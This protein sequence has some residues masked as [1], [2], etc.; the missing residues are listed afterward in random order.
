MSRQ[1][2]V[3][4]FTTTA[5]G[6]VPAPLTAT[7]TFL[8]DDGTWAAVPG[9]TS[10]LTTKGDIFG[11]STVN[12]RI[13]V[14]ADGTVLTADSTQALGVKWSAS[15]GSGTVT[16]VALLDGSST[17]IYTITGSPVTTAG[18]LT[19]TFKTQTANTV[20]AGPTSGGAAQPTF[21]TLVA[22]DGVVGIGGNV[23][24]LTQA[25]GA[26]QNYTVPTGANWLQVICVAGGGGGGSGGIQAPTIASTGGGGGGGGGISS[27]VFRAQDL[28]PTVTVTFSNAA[29]GGNGGASLAASGAGN[30]GVAGS[31]V[32]F[33]NHIIAYGGANGTGA[34][35]GA[36][37]LGMMASGTAGG[38]GGSGAGAGVSGT[39][40]SGGTL[41]ATG[42]GGG[43][44]TSTTN[45][46]TAGGAGGASPVTTPFMVLVGGTAGSS[47]AGGNGAASSGQMPA[48]GAGG[49]GAGATTVAGFAGGIGGTYGGGGGGG[50]AC[51]T[52]AVPLLSGAGGNGG[53]AACIIVAW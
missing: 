26:S 53:A 52:T 17:P 45:T 43:G 15:G 7:G 22:A 9:F 38:G 44:G 36:G 2:P 33:G 16:S 20:L 31:N 41:Q 18:T 27:A 4:R 10:P 25:G 50:G 23:T 3:N 34:A 13:P 1:L 47:S 28:A 48:S 11:F 12:A 29:T 46:A 14:G 8:R 5:Q 32:S 49:G 21:R 24:T 51:K 39:V 42:G 19:Y 40:Q 30:I 37:G 35:G 6:L